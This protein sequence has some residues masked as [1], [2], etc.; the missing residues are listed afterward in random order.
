MLDVDQV[1]AEVLDRVIQE[2]GIILDEKSLTAVGVTEST[3]FSEISLTSLDLA[4]L[5]SSVEAHYNVDPF[6][7]MVAITSVVTVGDFA[8][9]YSKCLSGEVEDDNLSEELRAIKNK[10]N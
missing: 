1:K 4:E 10:V 3:P 5:V 6:E 7:E 2:I 9:A 8:S